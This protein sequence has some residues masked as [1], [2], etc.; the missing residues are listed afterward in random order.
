MA[1]VCRE[2]TQT[3][4]HIAAHKPIAAQQHVGL[5]LQRAR[6]LQRLRMRLARFDARAEL[7]LQCLS[8][9]FLA[10]RKTPDASFAART[11]AQVT[12]HIDLRAEGLH[13]LFAASAIR[14]GYTPG[15]GLHRWNRRIEHKIRC[16]DA[17]RAV[18]PQHIRLAIYREPDRAGF[19]ALA[20]FQRAPVR[21]VTVRDHVGRS[22]F[23]QLRRERAASASSPGAI[24][25]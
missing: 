16:N 7:E 8:V 15:G 10:A 3:R 23:P 1:R 13:E 6:T 11:P 20:Q 25:S 17:A 4:R 21:A 5:R 18:T 9:E 2:C 14:L 22:L 24:A 19:V 12:Q